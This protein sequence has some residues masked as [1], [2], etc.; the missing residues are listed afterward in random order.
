MTHESAPSADSPRELL[1]TVRDLTR[2]VRVTQRD[3]WFPLLVFAV[4]TLAVIPVY[5]Y[6]P[7]HLGPCRSASRGISFCAS[8]IPGVLVYW[9]IALVLAYVVIAGFYVRRSRRRG[10]G[11]RVRPYVVA[12]IVIAV[13]A[14]AVALWRAFHPILPLVGT[15][16][17]GAPGTVFL[18]G[19]ATPWAAIGLALL[20]LTWVERSWALLLYSVVYLVIAAASF[21]RV[22]HSTSPL[23]LLPQLLIPAAVLLLGSAGFALFRPAAEPRP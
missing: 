7:Q 10:V 13:I 1:T 15:Q 6:A 18:H 19:L 16:V 22:I 8:F 21:G 5:L 20:V 3:T 11:T 23:A 14:A 2:R 12:G 4:V 9:S 17:S